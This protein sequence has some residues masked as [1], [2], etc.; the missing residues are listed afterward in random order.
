MS[1]EKLVEEDAFLVIMSI[2]SLQC[3]EGKLCLQINIDGINL[4]YILRKRDIQ[5]ET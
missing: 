2:Q 1:Y 5:D 4:S 3:L